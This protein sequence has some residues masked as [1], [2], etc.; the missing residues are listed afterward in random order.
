MTHNFQQV[1]E[2]IKDNIS[3]AVSVSI[4]RGSP[5]KGIYFSA[6]AVDQHDLRPNTWFRVYVDEEAKLIRLMRVRPDEP[7]PQTL[8]RLT[9]NKDTRTKAGAFN[10]QATMG[11]LF[12]RLG[13]SR[14][15]ATATQLTVEDNGNTLTF[16][17]KE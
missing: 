9:K 12:A 17:Y 8:V 10:L 1:T 11:R 7:D 5:S 14:E 2:P 3:G 16:S 13:I 15:K 6:K 4:L